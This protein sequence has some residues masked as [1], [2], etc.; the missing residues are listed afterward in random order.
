[1]G[2]AGF[3]SEGEFRSPI[4]IPSAP[5]D[6]SGDGGIGSLFAL[7]LEVKDRGANLPKGGG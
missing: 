5:V 1:M 3:K 7:N 6:G 4:A 2:P